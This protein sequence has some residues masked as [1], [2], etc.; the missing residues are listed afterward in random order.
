MC[1]ISSAF[2]ID[3]KG[4][5]QRGVEAPKN[6]IIIK[7]PQEAF[8]ENIRT[9]TSLL[10][11]IANNENLIIE[12]FSVGK[13]TRTKIAICYMDDIANSNLVEEVKYRLTNLSLDFINLNRAVRT[14]NYR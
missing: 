11:R 8:S 9:N 1:A 5:K 6:E 10:R 2:N 13:I 14:I 3:V 7:G 12:S 4:F